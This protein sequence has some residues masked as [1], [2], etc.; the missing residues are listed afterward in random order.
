MKILTYLFIIQISSVVLSVLKLIKVKTMINVLR[1][2]YG[3]FLIFSGFVK[4]VD[5]VGFSY[6]LQ[7][8]FEVFGMLWLND[9]TLILSIFICTFEIMLG[10]ILI[11]G[12]YTKIVLVLNLLMMLGFTFLTF[13]SAYFNVVTDCGCF[14]DFMKLDPWFSFQKDIV[15]VIVSSVLL[16]YRQLILPILDESKTKYS[17]L[18]ALFIFLFFPIY[19]ISKLPLIDFRPYKVGSNIAELRKLPSDAKLDVY[20]DIWYY[21][22]DGKTTEYKTEEKPWDIE[23]ASFVDRKTIL[24]QKGDEPKIKD[25]NIVSDLNKNDITD[26]VLSLDYVALVIIYDFDKSNSKGVE[27]VDNSINELSNIGIP[28]LTL[29]SSNF[30]NDKIL[31]KSKQISEAYNVDQT[32]LKTMI[33]S[34]PGI[35]LLNKGTVISKFHWRDAPNNWDE[36]IN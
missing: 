18:I 17:I 27:L 22:L 6:K 16:Y 24:V 23:G 1:F 28:S 9:F 14:G 7:E 33:R 12:S 11:L 34:N 29:S 32:T 26:S 36:Y 8:Y 25:F 20:D 2:S 19:G 21:E 3:P 5:P 4:T 35:I 31:D 15:F 30:L 10:F 13:F